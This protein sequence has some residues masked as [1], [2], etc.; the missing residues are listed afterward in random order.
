M[1]YQLR[2][3]PLRCTTSYD[4]K[5]KAST[6]PDAVPNRVGRVLGRRQR[7]SGADGFLARLALAGRT[8][9]RAVGGLG[10]AGQGRVG[11][12]AAGRPDP[13]GVE[14][15]GADAAAG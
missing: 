11:L 7:A 4:A 3:S 12:A 2:H 5:R 13:G 1:R 10:L 14:V 15:D 6:G 8:T 9:A